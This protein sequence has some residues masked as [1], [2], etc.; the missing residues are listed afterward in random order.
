MQAYSQ[1]SNPS[2]TQHAPPMLTEL[3]HLDALR[4]YRANDA[5]ARVVR[6]TMQQRRE[7]WSRGLRF[8]HSPPPS[9]HSSELHEL[10]SIPWSLGGNSF[11]QIPEPQRGTFGSSQHGPSQH[12]RTAPSQPPWHDVQFLGAT[13]VRPC[14]PLARSR[15][16]LPPP[17][18]S[19]ASA[20]RAA[21]AAEW[22]HACGAA[23]PASGS[24]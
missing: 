21:H 2:D 15:P 13:T 3:D 14:M 9:G 10:W 8:R 22:A 7:A 4:P 23:A 17:P 12:G 11:L 24:V 18:I 6:V 1:I 5:H 16:V 19:I 20:I